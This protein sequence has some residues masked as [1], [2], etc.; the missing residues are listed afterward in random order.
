[1]LTEP[2]R[3]RLL[4]LLAMFGSE[5]VGER[6]AAAAAAHRLVHAA[7][8]TWERIIVLPVRPPP[9]EP[10]PVPPD[11]RD[12]RERLRQRSWSTGLC[13]AELDVLIVIARTPEPTERQ[14]QAV[15]RIMAKI[16]AANR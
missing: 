15:A 11:R 10:I 5:H 3:D 12:E 7:G 16:L 2:D 1:V 8:L 13:D 4:R 14:N 9:P 6:S